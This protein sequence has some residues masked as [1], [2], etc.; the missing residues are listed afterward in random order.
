MYSDEI[1]IVE[2]GADSVVS[3]QLEKLELF[4]EGLNSLGIKCNIFCNTNPKKDFKRNSVS[5]NQLWVNRLRSILPGKIYVWFLEFLCYYRAFVRSNQ[6]QMRVLGLTVS[7]PYGVLIAY[8]LSRPKYGVTI[9]VLNFGLVS[10]SAGTYQVNKKCLNS[11]KFLISKG[12]NIVKLTNAGNSLLHPKETSKIGSVSTIPE[13]VSCPNI[14]VRIKSAPLSLLV[15]GC[16]D[17]HRRN[18]LMALVKG[19]Y[20]KGLTELHIHAPGHSYARLAD[21]SEYLPQQ[22]VKVKFTNNYITGGNLTNMVRSSSACLIAYQQ[23]FYN[24]SSVLYLSVMA[25]VPVLSSHFPDGDYSFDACGKL[26]EMF[27][28]ETEGDLS[29]AWGRFLEW[30]DL[31]YGKFSEAR[32]KL[33]AMVNPSTVARQHLDIFL[34]KI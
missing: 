14:G 25:G 28:M 6:K 16:D 15:V 23:G 18:A 17:G 21:G 1:I 33:R 11:W 34:R 19:G 22:G 8:L 3:H 2:P 12:V 30:G 13:I 20:L 31:E 5:C 7:A 24:P 29:R 27:K 26:G 9:R 4:L 32:K 10:I